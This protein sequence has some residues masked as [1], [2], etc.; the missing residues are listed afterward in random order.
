MKRYKNAKYYD[1]QLDYTWNDP[2]GDAVQDQ[3]ESKAYFKEGKWR[4]L[5]LLR[6]IMS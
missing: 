6:M 3:D 2:K 5:E 4:Q 1:F